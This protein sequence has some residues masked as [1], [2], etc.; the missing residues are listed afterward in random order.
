MLFAAT[1]YAS[2]PP[3]PQALE[4]FESKVRPILAQNCHE[5]HGP[6]K[7][8]SDLRLDHIEFILKGGERGPA[9]DRGEPARSR[10]LEAVRYENLDLQMP[11]KKKLGDE[12]I[13]MIERWVKMGAP[14]PDEPTPAN[15]ADKKEK[16]ETF[17]LRQRKAEHWSWK[18][19]RVE[20]P[21]IKNSAWPLND[22]DRYILAGLEREGLEPAPPADKRTWLRR[23]YFDLTGLPP[24]PQQVEAFE[25]DASAQ[26][27]EKVVDELLRSPHFGERWAR[28]WLDLVRYAETYGHEFDYPIAE[29]WR[30]RD[31]VIRAL[32]ADLP[33]DQFVREHLAGDLLDPPRPHPT[34]GYNE[35][36]IATGAWF[37]HEQTH[38]PTDVRQHEADRIDNQL[39]V[40]SKALLGLTVSCARCHDH[41]FDAISTQ[42]YYALAGFLRSSHQQYALLD[43]YGKIEQGVK[44][45]KNLRE[46]ADKLLARPGAAGSLFASAPVDKPPVAAADPQL[47]EDFSADS[48][49]DWSVTGWAFGD[50]PT[51]PRL[52]AGVQQPNDVVLNGEKGLAH[53]GWLAEKLS[54][55]LCSRTFIID[56]PFI[57]VRA[58]GKSS[59]IRVIIDGY[60]MD[61]FNA[62]LFRGLTLNV[63]T[64]DGFKW[65]TI[66]GDYARYRGHRAHIEFLDHGDGWIA[67]DEILFS[68]GPPPPDPPQI[69]QPPLIPQELRPKLDE[70]AAQMKRINDE[71]PHPVRVLAMTDGTGEDS[72]VFVRG[73]H[74]TP[75][76]TAPRRMLEAISGTDQQPISRGSGRLELARRILA[77]D[78]PY[79]ARVIV[80]RLWHHLFGRGI[81]PTVDNFGVLG[82]PPSHPQ[83]LDYL[84]DRL[85]KEHWSLKAMIRQMVLSQTYRMSSQPGD[86]PGE[87]KDPTNT[88]LHRMNVKRLE[89]EAIRDA[90]LAISGRLDQRMYGPPVPT[91]LTPF[92]EGRGRPKE[93]GP[94]DGAGRRSLYLEVRRNFLNPMMLAFDTPV[95]FTAFGQ[96][97]VSNVPAQALILMND[98]F[99]AEQ[100]GLWA[101]RILADQSLRTPQQ[102]I[103]QMYLTAFAR[104][105]GEDETREA[106]EF[107]KQQSGF[108]ES[109]T[110]PWDSAQAWTDLAHVLMNIKEFIFIH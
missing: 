100:A 94:L 34:E 106:M 87:S 63:D 58:A 42:D 107:L 39:D 60:T 29:A 52:G 19:I 57:H 10:I 80:N 62:L 65:L 28:H 46:R 16:A 82:Q 53:S 69:A 64:A 36:V 30:Y 77:D 38:A 49:K 55:A 59:Q 102:R 1:A 105:P 35:S 92:M 76:P 21:G 85:K 23:V 91:H 66:G 44:Q 14:W 79:P 8:K 108:Y 50:G 104:P 56:K 15:G 103:Q 40:M 67:V 70:I 41:K 110:G 54:G 90:V 13:A 47:F 22:L 5:C 26:A 32:N 96:R 27:C 74:R 7:Q 17:N 51:K 37:F 3:D 99:V 101:R 97:T 20:M 81:V 11:P 86:G 61:A 84:A 71:I 43:P 83:L 78:N 98:P 4:F 95:P 2:D 31:Y 68:D 72:R 9:V 24:S 45:L 6:K 18:P 25:I 12:Q 88:L 48:Y 73:S 33:Y 89:G 75:G 93:S 109:R